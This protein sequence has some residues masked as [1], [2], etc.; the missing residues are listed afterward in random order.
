MNSTFLDEATCQDDRIEGCKA[1]ITSNCVRSIADLAERYQNKMII[2][3]QKSSKLIWL[4]LYVNT[5]TQFQKFQTLQS[6]RPLSSA[7]ANSTSIK[8]NE[9]I[10]E[11]NEMNKTRFKDTK[12]NLPPIND[13]ESKTKIPKEGISPSE[14]EIV[15]RSVTVPISTTLDVTK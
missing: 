9:I 4:L 13:D 3:L 14:L 1:F 6:D 5:A 7:Y 15:D 2:S 12:C 11:N 8:L 10:T